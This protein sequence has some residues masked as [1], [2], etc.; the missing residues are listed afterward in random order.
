MVDF[1][2]ISC[3]QGG[4]PPQIINLNLAINDISKLEVYDEC[5]NLYTELKYAYSV[6]SACWSC[7]MSYDEILENTIELVSDFYVRLRIQ[8]NISKI[9][10]DGEEINDFST[11]LES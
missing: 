2:N 6:D 8:G 11:Q 1:K 3:I 4:K 10:L 9:L 7:Y 5:N